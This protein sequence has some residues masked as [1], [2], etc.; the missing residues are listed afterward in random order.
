MTSARSAWAGSRCSPPSSTSRSASTAVS[1]S[2]WVRYSGAKPQRT[3]S[4]ARK[5]PTTPRPA[6]ARTTPY[7]SGWAS[8][9]RVSALA[10]ADGLV[11]VGRDE[12]VVLA[13]PPWVATE[14][15]PGLEA[16]DDFRAILI[17]APEVPR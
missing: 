10:F 4:G 13:V 5:S 15:V 11:P 14:L 12:A 6:R 9:T 16:P 2:A 1:A 17:E 3:R 8:A 7:A